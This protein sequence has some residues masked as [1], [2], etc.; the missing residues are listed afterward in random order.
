MYDETSKK[1]VKTKMQPKM[2]RTKIFVI[3]LVEHKVILFF[4]Y[5]FI[6]VYF[7]AVKCCLER[8]IRRFAWKISQYGYNFENDRVTGSSYLS[9]L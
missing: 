5:L 9:I 2:S 8:K 3:Y 6:F 1:Y 4:H 7:I